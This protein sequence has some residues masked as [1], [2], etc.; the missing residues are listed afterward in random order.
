M[1]IEQL[2]F[3]R[4]IAAIAIVIFHFGKGVFPFN[5][6]GL[7]T[8]ISYGYV[9]VSYFFTLSGFVMIVAYSKGGAKI[10]LKSYYINRVAKIYPVY[11]IA[12]LLALFTLQQIA[13]DRLALEAFLVHSFIPQY[14]SSYNSPD[15]SLS[16]ELLFYLLFPLLYNKFYLKSSLLKTGLIIIAVWLASQ[17]LNYTL[18]LN[19]NPAEIFRNFAYYNP[20]VHLNEF[21]IGNLLGLTYLFCLQKNYLAGDRWLL[22]LGVILL[23]GVLAFPFLKPFVVKSTVNI[24]N[25]LF[26]VFFAPLILL[27][28]LNKGYVSKVL[29][30]PALIFLGEISYCIYILQLPLHTFFKRF[31][32][33]ENQAMSLYL[34]VAFLIACSS[35]VYLWVE[36][37]AKR[38][39]RK[40]F[41]NTSYKI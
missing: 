6:H 22:F 35:V 27:L 34:Y 11:I 32:T 28:S 15:W 14:A 23:C 7:S 13:I 30:L 16:V 2:T 19:Y 41:K 37:P 26:I 20:L 5:A 18:W 36:I 29:S 39:I 4:F 31:F 24:H 40:Y 9:G 38:L 33:M 12:L 3:T 25:G 10:S 1:R 17:A 8:L 21:L